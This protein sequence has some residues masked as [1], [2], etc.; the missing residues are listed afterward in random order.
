MRNPNYPFKPSRQKKGLKIVSFFLS[1]PIHYGTKVAV[2][3]LQTSSSTISSQ[4]QM[5]RTPLELNSNKIQISII[6]IIFTLS[7]LIFYF[8]L[9]WWLFP[10]LLI[11]I[12]LRLCLLPKYIPLE[13]FLKNEAQFKKET[14]QEDLK[15]YKRIAIFEFINNIIQT[16]LY[17]I[18]FAIVIYRLFMFYEDSEFSVI[19][20]ISIIT[21][22]FLD[23]KYS[24]HAIKHMEECIAQNPSFKKQ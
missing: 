4:K 23:L 1:L 24:I 6:S 12:I 11:N 20:L 13:Y 18:F 14:I 7:T 21:W 17:L 19:L 10:C 3:S 16:I 5:R 15:F 2:E 22:E 8:V 9:E